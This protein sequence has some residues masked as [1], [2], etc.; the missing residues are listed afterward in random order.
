MARIEL[1][2]YLDDWG[3]SDPVAQLSKSLPWNARY[4]RIVALAFRNKC[5]KHRR[6]MSCFSR[7]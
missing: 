5:P 3:L 2:T 7:A 1:R 4:R 6:P